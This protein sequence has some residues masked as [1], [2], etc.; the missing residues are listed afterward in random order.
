MITDYKTLI[1]KAN[2]N[3]A[4][5]VCDDGDF[6]HGAELPSELLLKAVEALELIKDKAP[7]C[8]CMDAPAIANEALLE[9]RAALEG[10]K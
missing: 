3:I 2:E 9:I 4:S 6:M 5:R 8:E 1:E 7:F 10:V